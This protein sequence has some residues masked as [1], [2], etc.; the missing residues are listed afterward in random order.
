MYC[1]SLFIFLGLYYSAASSQIMVEYYGAA[2]EGY[3]SSSRGDSIDLS[4]R[5]FTAPMSDELCKNADVG[6][7]FVSPRPVMVLYTG[8]TFSIADLQLDAINAND[9]YIKNVPIVV[10]LPEIRDGFMSY[11]PYELNLIAVNPGSMQIEIMGYCIPGSRTYLTL[12]VL[13]TRDVS[14]DRFSML[15]PNSWTH[16]EA[17][18]PNS[19]KTIILRSKL[20]GSELRIKNLSTPT[21]ITSQQ[22]RL[23]TNVP[24]SI[25]LSLEKWGEYTG[26]NYENFENNTFYMHWWLTSQN[27]LLLATYSSTLENETE[28]ETVIKIISS[29]KKR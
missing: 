27:D 4:Y 14:A 6:T 12:I 2:G 21:S 11:D 23:L 17:T 24:E 20:P 22:L 19:V 26:F 18:G 13:K 15:T 28:K 1:R 8:E 3:T 9:E 7:Y 16:Q 25:N 10:G 29:I 5:M